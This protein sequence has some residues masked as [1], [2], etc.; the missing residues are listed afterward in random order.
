MKSLTNVI[1]K[2]SHRGIQFKSKKEVFLAAL[3]FMDF[4]VG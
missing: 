1:I 2:N 3:A 4:L